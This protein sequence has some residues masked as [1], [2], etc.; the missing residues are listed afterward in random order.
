ML[1]TVHACTLTEQLKL[2]AH[3][4]HATCQ[5]G[6]AAAALILARA[7]RW[8]GLLLQ[9]LAAAAVLPGTLTA[10]AADRRTLPTCQLNPYPEHH[11]PLPW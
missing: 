9:R 11:L 1:L 7:G 5:T 8:S 10:A 2:V 4:A 6:A 3:L